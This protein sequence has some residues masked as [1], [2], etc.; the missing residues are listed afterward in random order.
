MVIMKA[1]FNMENSICLWYLNTR[2]LV[3]FTQSQ[4]IERSDL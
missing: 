2:F 3:I 1:G 4:V